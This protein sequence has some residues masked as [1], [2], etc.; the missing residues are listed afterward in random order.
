[1]YPSMQFPGRPLSIQQSHCE[2]SNSLSFVIFSVIACLEECKHG[3]RYFLFALFR[4]YLLLLLHS[5]SILVIFAIVWLLRQKGGGRLFDELRHTSHQPI[6]FDAPY[7]FYCFNS[8]SCI[9]RVLS[10]IRL[11]VNGFVFL[12]TGS[13]TRRWI[14]DGVTTSWYFLITL[15][16]HAQ[17]VYYKTAYPM[18]REWIPKLK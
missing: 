6:W 18:K 12:R 4:S 8:L 10:R 17:N 3:C 9:L 14:E 1:M 7:F 5:S 15:I 16:L 2:V 13:G 11:T